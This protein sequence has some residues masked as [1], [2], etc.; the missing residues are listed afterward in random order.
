MRF[1]SINSGLFV[2]IACGL[3]LSTAAPVSFVTEE[4]EYRLGE[5]V[6]I[7]LKIDAR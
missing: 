4:V 5:S 2:W 1:F 3:S 7:P 6:M